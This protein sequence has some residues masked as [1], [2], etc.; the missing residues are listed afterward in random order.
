MWQTCEAKV[1]GTILKKKIQEIF[2]KSKGNI[3]KNIRGGWRRTQEAKVA[4]NIH[5]SRQLLSASFPTTENGDGDLASRFHE[6]N[7]FNISKHRKNCETALTPGRYSKYSRIVKFGWIVKFDQ[8]PSVWSGRVTN[9]PKSG[10][11][12]DFHIDV[13]FINPP[14]ID[15]YHTKERPVSSNWKCPYCIIRIW[16]VS[17]RCAWQ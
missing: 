16:V 4:G 9:L 8:L 3:P 14:C 2:P 10:F 1:A 13:K 5:V 11:S 15:F 6:K 12:A 7:Y 17:I